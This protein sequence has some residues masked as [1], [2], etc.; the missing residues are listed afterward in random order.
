M[1]R[2]TDF[3][4]DPFFIMAIGEKK[5]GRGVRTNLQMF[6]RDKILVDSEV[7]KKHSH[8]CGS[9]TPQRTLQ[10]K[11]KCLIALFCLSKAKKKSH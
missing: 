8:W 1:G 5:E 10:Q 2:R 3:L 6:K 11:R 7:V 9:A 4:T